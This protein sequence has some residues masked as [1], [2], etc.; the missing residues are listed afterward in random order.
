MIDINY[1]TAVPFTVALILSVIDNPLL[2]IPSVP[3]IGFK[4]K[5][6]F[7]S[8]AKSGSIEI[9]TGNPVTIPSIPVG[10]LNKKSSPGNNGAGSFPL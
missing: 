10:R 3:V 2:F 5:G 9:T 8:P 7:G 4:K 1:R 6:A